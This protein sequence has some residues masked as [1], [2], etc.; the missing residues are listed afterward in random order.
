MTR[1]ILE[2]ITECGKIIGYKIYMKKRKNYFPYTSN[3][4]LR[5][6]IKKKLKQHT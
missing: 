6:N 2:L 1:Q 3:E 4:Q 5:V